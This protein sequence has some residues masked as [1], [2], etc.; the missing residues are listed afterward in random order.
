MH[1]S[2]TLGRITAAALFAV[3][4]LIV[5]VSTAMADSAS[6]NFESPTY[7]VGNINGQDGWSATGSAGSGCAVYDEGVANSSV[8]GFGSQSFRISNAVTS[9]CFGDQ[10]FSKSL[11][12]EAGETT[13]QNGGISGGTRQ[14]HF[15]AQFD[16]ASASST[17]QPGLIM[18]VSP[19]RGDGAR[20]SYLRFEDKTDGIH[21]FFDDVNSVGDFIETD[22]ATL[23]RTPH[24]IKFV[25]DFIDG[26]NN[27]I[28]KIYI[29]G[30]LK[31]TGTSWENYFN[32]SES[33]PTRTVDSLLFRAGGTAAPTNAGAGFYIDNL[34]LM[35]GPT[36]TPTPVN[37]TIVKYVNE[38][39][40]TAGNANSAVF[41]MQAV[42]SF[43]NDQFP[44]GIS[45]TDPYDIGP[46][47]NNTPDMYEAKTLQFYPGADYSTYERTD[48]SVVGA[49]CQDGKPFALNG[50][51]SGDSLAAAQ[52]AA[53]SS[54][55]P[56]F[57]NLQSNKYV[58]VH[59]KTC[60]APASDVTVT[61]VKYVGGI[62]ATAGNASSTSFPMQS[63]WNAANLGGAGSG[64][65]ALSTV[66]YNSPNAYEAM[67]SNMTSGSSYATNEDLSTSAVGAAC[68]NN[69]QNPQ[70]R[71]AGYTSGDSL[72]AA[73]VGMLSSTSPSFTNITTNKYVIVWNVPCPVPPPVNPGPPANACATPGVAPQGYTL[74][75][76]TSKADNVT[77]APN[78][79]FVGMGGNDKV[80]AGNGSY[81][82]C[83]GSGN[84]MITLGNGDSVVDAGAGN[85]LVE[86]G[87]GMTRVT[88]GSGNDQI[89]TGSGNDT[90]NAGG[91]NNSVNTNGGNDSITTGSGN[92]SANGGAGTDTCSLGGGNNSKSGC[93]L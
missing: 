55:A 6:I 65:Y 47:G 10:A 69:P 85:N 20:M 35:S 72:A 58:I 30:V 18:S 41:P 82:V 80:T 54:Q 2:L 93:E 45:G 15:E 51:S 37:V 25:M 38:T 42:Y 59:N 19:D 34:S 21:V 53:T 57:T 76:G 33:N 75:N 46:T 74:R 40:A 43:T 67:T 11:A 36:P 26:A 88:T 17:Q 73:Q 52:A 16:I 28:V 14:N 1:R 7:T 63:S 12:N 50:Y 71:L 48:T 79:M 39:H 86:L 77:L 87:N 29:D 60:A 22:I 13:A 84:D 9:G 62:H 68:T 27:D 49:T 92:D 4:A 5:G 64:S 66:G 8:P 56:A 44:N 91:G 3:A 89:T 78:T 61:I 90:I 31:I 83:T 70:F 81:I 23:T 32:V 24:T